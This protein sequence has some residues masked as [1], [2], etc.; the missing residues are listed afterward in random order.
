MHGRLNFFCYGAK[1]CLWH[2]RFSEYR[3]TAHEYGGLAEHKAHA[4]RYLLRN[5]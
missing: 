2:A 1:L 4:A 3:Q 5:T